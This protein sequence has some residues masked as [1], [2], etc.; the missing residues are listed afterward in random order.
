MNFDWC[1]PVMT[2]HCPLSQTFLPTRE[3]MWPSPGNVLLREVRQEGAF[4]GHFAELVKEKGMFG[5]NIIE[6]LSL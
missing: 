2:T 3:V 5:T 6:P 4:G 1:K